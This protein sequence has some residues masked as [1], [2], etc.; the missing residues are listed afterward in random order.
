MHLNDSITVLKGVGKQRAADL[1]KLGI[2]TVGDLLGH[3][4]Y[5]YEDR[6]QLK[7]LRDMKEGDTETVTGIIVQAQDI[8][9]RR[10]LK[11]LRVSIRCADG[12]AVLV[13]FNQN[14]LKNKLQP[15]LQ[16]LA[17]GKVGKG[18][19]RQ[20]SVT[21]FELIEDEDDLADFQRI[22][23]VYRGTERNSGKQIRKL[24]VQTMAQEIEGLEEFLPDEHLQKYHLM[25]YGDA[26]QQIHFPEEWQKLNRA[27]HRL[28]FNEF[29]ELTLGLQ[30]HS[31][32]EKKTG[33]AHVQE[34]SL[35]A[36]FFK[37]LPFGLTNAQKKVILEVKKD[38]E[39][40]VAMKRLV[41]GDVGS[42]KTMIAVYALLK[43]V[44]GGYQA[45]MMAPTE[46]LAEQHYLNLKRMLEPLGIEPVLLTGSLTRKERE[47]IY[48]KI[49]D[50]TCRIAVGTHALIQKQ[51]Q[52][53]NLGVVVIDE[54]HRFGVR[55]RL[56]LENKGMAPDVL[57]MTATPI[58]RSLALTLYGDMDLSIIDE[59][60]PGRQSVK[61]YCM[62][63][64]K[65]RDLYRFL[66]EQ[67]ASGY[68]VYV[69]CP[70][71]EESEKMDL[72]NATQLA[73]HLAAN[74]FP[75]YAV[76]LLHG[77]MRPQEKAEI[78][79]QFRD[80]QLQILVSTTVIE[81]GVD[82]PNAN[83]MVIE[84]AERFGLA[85]LHQLRGRVGRGTT[86]AHCFLISEPKT[87][88]G[89]RRMQV[90]VK[91]TDGFV[92]AEEDLLLRG[93]GEV[94]GTRQHGLPD[95]KI[96]DLVHDVKILE[97]SRML[98]DEITEIGLEQPQYELLRKKAEAIYQR[99]MDLGE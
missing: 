28:V 11:I 33:I 21:D 41:Q 5:R 55:Q 59:L 29:L 48:E 14:H 72:E 53:A 69:V 86:Q 56:A 23:P 49:S 12:N 47:T 45:V 82:V 38:M 19:L 98:A 77:K 66:G 13:W 43:A 6:S 18:S 30:L 87:D 57:V 27:R 25:D 16:I 4:P 62:G 9:P 76:G 85:Q 64:N 93:A 73:D 78:M 68:Q 99:K 51:V 63:E 54:Q 50:G 36:Q 83:V 89:K 2:A 75:Q 35:A 24:V 42:G 88:E 60:P 58:P 17:T 8:Y 96:A 40:P 81:V 94:L 31:L 74:V 52:F 70:L 34:E 92:I 7:P 79:E 32:I 90:M 46:I 22:V 80:N 10:G 84:N 20:I 39:R 3:Y 1:Q 71:V 97:Q 91:S 61:T 15:G 26:V 95:L 44:T 65:R 67:I 37:G